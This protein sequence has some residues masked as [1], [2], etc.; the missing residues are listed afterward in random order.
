MFQIMKVSASNNT[1]ILHRS[2]WKQIPTQSVIKH[3]R[4]FVKIMIRN[5]NQSDDVE[6][7][8]KS[9]S[10]SSFPDRAAKEQCAS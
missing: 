4:N 6:E 1:S 10:I 7:G 3:L 8:N 5:E 9:I 2:L